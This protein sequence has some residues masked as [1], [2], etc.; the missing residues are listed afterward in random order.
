MTDEQELEYYRK[1]KQK[2]QLIELPF[3]INQ[4][5]YETTKATCDVYGFGIRVGNC[6]YIGMNHEC[7][8]PGFECPET[9]IQVKA[10]LD[11]QMKWIES[12]SIGKTVF[13]SKEQARDYLIKDA[14]R[15]GKHPDM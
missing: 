4:V 10:T 13:T 12:D 2:G 15:K 9:I 7:M 14:L 8:R 1:L 6:P 3:P 5:V 11:N